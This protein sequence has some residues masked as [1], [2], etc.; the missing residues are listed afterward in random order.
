MIRRYKNLLRSLINHAGL[1][2]LWFEVGST[3]TAPGEFAVALRRTPL[4][5]TF[6]EVPSSHHHF[7]IRYTL[8]SPTF[9]TQ[10]FGAD[11]N[12]ATLSADEAMRRFKFWLEEHVKL[13]REEST[14]PDL[15]EQVEALSMTDVPSIISQHNTSNFSNDEK[16]QIR[17]SLRNFQQAVINNFVPSQKQIE[18][19]Q[20]KLKYL[21]DSL[22][23]LPRFDWFGTA[24]STILAIG[25]ALSLDTEKGKL[26]YNLFK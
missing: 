8:Y 11:S 16:I 9:Q 21:S 25:I 3:D 18:D 5:F 2:P 10:Q 13:Y 1:D 7:R 4:K 24:I 17:I 22:E 26:L 12:E 23:R 6:F 19:I 15:W 14:L 20:Q